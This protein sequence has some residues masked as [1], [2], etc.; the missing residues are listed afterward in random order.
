[1]NIFQTDSGDNLLLLTC[2]RNWLWCCFKA[3]IDKVLRK[4]FSS[5]SMM[6]TQE[7]F[8]LF[9]IIFLVLTTQKQI[10]IFVTYVWLKVLFH[11]LRF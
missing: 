9:E 1:M 10:Y 4:K 3:K 7:C 6:V 8:F 5:N 2:S 11:T